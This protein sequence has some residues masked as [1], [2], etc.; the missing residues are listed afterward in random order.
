ML[1]FEKCTC[2]GKKKMS[3]ICALPRHVQVTVIFLAGLVCS[4]YCLEHL[5]DFQSRAKRK[6]SGKSLQSAHFLPWDRSRRALNP[7]IETSGFLVLNREIGTA[8]GSRGEGGSGTGSSPAAGPF[9]GRLVKCMQVF[10]VTLGVNRSA[11]QCGSLP[12]YV[13]TFLTVPFRR[14]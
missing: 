13:G 5:L 11:Q 1:I 8:R 10:K 12:F 14:A 4:R 7:R 3:F 6:Y 2:W 9:P